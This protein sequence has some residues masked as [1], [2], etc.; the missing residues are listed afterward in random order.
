MNNDDGD[1]EDDE[2]VEGRRWRKQQKK[3]SF[4]PSVM[5]HMV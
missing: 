5:W 2:E 4:T 1:V 3:E